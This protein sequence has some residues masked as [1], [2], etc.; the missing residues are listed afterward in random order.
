MKYNNLEREKERVEE[1]L[2]SSDDKVRSKLLKQVEDYEK[3]CSYRPPHFESTENSVLPQ[4]NPLKSAA[5]VKD[6]REQIAVSE[7]LYKIPIKVRNSTNQLHV[8]NSNSVGKGVKYISNIG[9]IR[10]R[11]GQVINSVENFQMIPK[12]LGSGEKRSR[13][14]DDFNKDPM[15]QPPPLR[16]PYKSSTSPTDPKTS[17]NNKQAVPAASSTS[18]KTKRSSTLANNSHRLKS[19]QL[20]LG[21][22]PVPDNFEELIKNEDKDESGNNNNRYANVIEG[23]SGKN[24]D[25]E[26]ENGAHEVKDNDFNLVDDKNDGKDHLLEVLDNVNNNAAEEDTNNIDAKQGDGGHMIGD[27]VLVAPNQNLLE[28]V[29]KEHDGGNDDIDIVENNKN[30]ML[31]HDEDDK[32]KNEVDGDEGKEIVARHDAHEEQNEE[33][34]DDGEY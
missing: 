23:L 9:N 15:Q 2:R 4:P 26:Q 8:T 7:N 13:Q 14:Q 5:L 24:E 30:P 18:E 17:E 33:D 29:K 31:R 28:S 20:P 12:P 11:N 21:V 27:G 10:S 32:L 25:P 1:L 3:H 22:A 16:V 34:G 6:F 19:K